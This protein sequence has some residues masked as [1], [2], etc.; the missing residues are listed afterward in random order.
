MQYRTGKHGE[1][2][3]LLGYGCMRFT[4]KGGGI[5]L[6]SVLGAVTGGKIDLGTILGAIVGGSQ[7]SGG[8]A[9]SLSNANIGEIAQ[10]VISV[11]GMASNAFGSAK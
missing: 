5:D 7:P 9:G 3:S 6:G 1:A 2:L 11:I 10:S 8:L 4:R